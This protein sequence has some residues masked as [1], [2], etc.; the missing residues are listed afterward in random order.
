MPIECDTYQ[1]EAE[2]VGGSTIKRRSDTNAVAVI[3]FLV[4]HP[5]VASIPNGIQVVTDIPRGSV[6]RTLSQ[7][8]DCGLV[9]H[10]VSLSNYAIAGQY[11]SDHCVNNYIDRR[12]AGAGGNIK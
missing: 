7:L 10:V 12:L 6:G 9:S 8:E 3:Q 2:M 1:G 11:G 5:D 4:T